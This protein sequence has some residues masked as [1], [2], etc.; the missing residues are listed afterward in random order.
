MYLGFCL[1]LKGKYIYDIFV[2]ILY[3]KNFGDLDVK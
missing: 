2:L 1:V 3:N